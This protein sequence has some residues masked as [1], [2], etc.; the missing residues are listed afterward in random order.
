SRAT[1]RRP[2]RT[3]LLRRGP[4]QSWTQRRNPDGLPLSLHRYLA[5]YRR[6]QPGAMRLSTRS[7]PARNSE[8]LP[9]PSSEYADA[10][11]DVRKVGRI[12]LSL[13][14]ELGKTFT[15]R[16]GKTGGPLIPIGHYAGLIDLGGSSAL[17]LHTDGVGTKVLIAQLMKKFD[18]IGIDCVAM[19]VNDLVCLGAEPVALLDYIALQR[20]NQAL[21]SQLTKGLAEGAKLASTA[22]VGGETAILGGMVKG[23]GG[24]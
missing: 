6:R 3:G 8:G 24:N 10:G 11:V 14:E 23:T 21:V 18:T 1:T 16:K 19:T 4:R 5:G 13:A 7:F 2:S 12:H 20:E 17:A 22:I 9:L 15:N